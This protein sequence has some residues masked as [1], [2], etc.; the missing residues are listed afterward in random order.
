MNT[1]NLNM[2]NVSK[3]NLYK[4]GLSAKFFLYFDWLFPTGELLEYYKSDDVD[5]KSY[6]EQKTLAQLWSFLLH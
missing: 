6:L 3:N 1:K 5:T 2:T 4:K